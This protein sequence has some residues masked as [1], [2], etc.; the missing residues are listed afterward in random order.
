MIKEKFLNLIRKYSENEDYN[1][2]CWNEIENNYSSKSRHYHNLEHLENML[3]ELNKIQSEIKD[4]DCLLFAIYYHD[5]IYKPTKSNN[6]HQSA[7]TFKSR[8]AKTSFDKLNECMSQIEAT[9][10]H[11][12]S[13]DYDT[14][15]LLDLDLSVLGKNPQEYKEYCE[16][17]RKEYQIY[18]DFMY[19]KGRKKVL[20]NILELDFIYKTDYFKQLYENQAKENLKLELKQLS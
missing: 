8:I 12:I 3:S 19:R 7:L 2:E 16:S 5:I 13:N 1:L 4:L 6:E 15:I 18:P 17:I 20:K 10:E 9:K 14:S 11:K